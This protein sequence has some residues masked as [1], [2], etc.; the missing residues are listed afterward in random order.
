MVRVAR[1][2]ADSNTTVCGVAKRTVT[3]VPLE[4]GGGHVWTVRAQPSAPPHARTAQQTMWN[5]VR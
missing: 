2:P 3:G 5:E 4:S 1:L